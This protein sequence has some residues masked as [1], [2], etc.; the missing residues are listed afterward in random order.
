MSEDCE[1]KTYQNISK[2]K[3]DY[4]RQQL[5]GD[6]ATITG[7]NPW[8]VDTHKG[9][10][11]ITST[12]KLRAT[13]NEPAKTLTIEITDKPGV[14]SCEKV[15]SVIDEQFQPIL[16]MKDPTEAT[17]PSS[18]AKP[19][20]ANVVF[21]LDR[22]AIASIVRQAAEDESRKKAAL[23]MTLAVAGGLGYFMFKSMKERRGGLVP[24]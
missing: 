17:P 9:G 15:W 18:P 8:D 20:R 1:V 5:A 16:A 7:D 13:W 3:I 10:S 21:I 12:V 11:I 22:P 24:T 4:L 14:A 19:S 2:Y 6:G 23:V